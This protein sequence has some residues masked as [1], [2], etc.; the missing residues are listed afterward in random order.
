MKLI[1]FIF[2][3]TLLACYYVD[4]IIDVGKM[5][6]Y[7]FK[8]NM[9]YKDDPNDYWQ[10]PEESYKLK[11]GDCED[12]AV[13]FMYLCKVKLNINCA[14][15]MVTS[16]GGKHVVVKINNVYYDTIHNYSSDRIRNGWSIF[17]E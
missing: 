17:W 14:L 3:L 1:T 8:N 5:T 13:L 6:G 4:E 10:L 2:L 7:D 9:S 12:Y 15:V 11:T 16:D